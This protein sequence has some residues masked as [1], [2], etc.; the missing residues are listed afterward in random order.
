MK[1]KASPVETVSKRPRTENHLYDVVR[2]LDALSQD[3]L[4][5]VMAEAQKRF[6]LFL[7]D[8]VESVP[9]EVWN[10]LF[11]F[12]SLKMVCT[13]PL[14]S[15]PVPNFFSEI[16]TA[17]SSLDLSVS[18]KIV[19]KLERFHNGRLLFRKTERSQAF[20]LLTMVRR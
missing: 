10:L 14:H 2:R 13:R 6:Q 12:C 15:V 5:I 20:Q 3:E 4:V 18:L 7:G 11:N 16:P 8:L 19:F 17:V 1:R 9:N